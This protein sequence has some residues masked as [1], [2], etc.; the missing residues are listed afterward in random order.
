MNRAYTAMIN[1]LHKAGFIPKKHILDN[2]CS[3]ELKT[4]IKEK[5]L[6]QLVPPGSHRANLAEV[7]IKAFKQH[8]ISILA[9]TAVDF[10]LSFWDE[11]LPQASLTLNLLCKSNAT[12][13]VSAHAHLSGQHDYN[14]KPLLPMG[15]SAEVLEKRANRKSW[16]YHS[17]PAWYL[18]TSDEHY[19][20]NAFLMKKSKRNASQTQR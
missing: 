11:L 1:R 16:D 12:P 3:E 14:A 19:R 18:Y 17:K 15:Q 5:C 6:L 9:G 20:T 4:A 13:T 2:E 10:P 7:S 8:L